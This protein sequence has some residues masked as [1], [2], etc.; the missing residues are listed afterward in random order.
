MVKGKLPIFFHNVLVLIDPGSTHSYLTL[1]FVSLINRIRQEILFRLFISTFL[2][3]E[4]EFD[5]IYPN[6][7]ILLGGIGDLMLLPFEDYNIILGMDWLSRHY[8]G[9]DCKNKTIQ[10]CRLKKDIIEFKGEK[11]QEN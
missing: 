7:E 9:I 5:R 1:T 8:V 2:G 10:F 11:S 4:V 6:C 3:K